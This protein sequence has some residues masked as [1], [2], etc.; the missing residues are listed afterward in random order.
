MMDR[1]LLRNRKF[2]RRSLRYLIGVSP[3]LVL[4]PVRGVAEGLRAA[5]ELAG[6]RFLAG[7]GPEVRL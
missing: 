4:G 1:L 3:V 7:V 5:G 6:V 2:L